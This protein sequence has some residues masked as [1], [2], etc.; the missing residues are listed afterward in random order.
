LVIIERAH[1]LYL[2]GAPLNGTE[3]CQRSQTHYGSQSR[4]IVFLV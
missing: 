1:L 4:L 2:L 3:V